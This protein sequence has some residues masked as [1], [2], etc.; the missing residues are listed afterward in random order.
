ME[1]QQSIIAKVHEA[2][3]VLLA[4]DPQAALRTLDALGD[5][6]FATLEIVRGE[7]LYTLQEFEQARDAFKKAI[8]FC[9]NS[10]RAEIL[11]ELTTSMLKL[12]QAGSPAPTLGLLFEEP[13]ADDRLTLQELSKAL[14]P[15]REALEQSI[16]N[17]APEV[18]DERLEAQPEEPEIGLV[19]ETLARIMIKQGK[20]DEA[21]KVYIQLARLDPD[22]YPYFRDRMAELDEMAVTKS[23]S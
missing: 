11:I 6:S 19:S 20:L 10:P 5:V 15:E 12:R 9:P 22:R 1:E 13:I 7:C 17:S 21:R 8:L 3:R 4:G 14:L 18:A 2:R 16:P 23:A